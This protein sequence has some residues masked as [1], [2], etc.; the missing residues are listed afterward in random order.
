MKKKTIIN[1]YDEEINTIYNQKIYIMDVTFEKNK[2]NKI[3][4][5]F[6]NYHIKDDCKLIEYNLS[7]INNLWSTDSCYLEQYN[8][9]SKDKKIKYLNSRIDLYNNKVD[10]PA[11]IYFENGRITFVNGR[12]RF[13]NL[14][15]LGVE[16]MHFLVS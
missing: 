11:Q 5:N 10:T 15:D 7:Y 14:R 6:S 13:C 9:L 16:K 2:I 12:H 3:L 4:N 8:K 1:T